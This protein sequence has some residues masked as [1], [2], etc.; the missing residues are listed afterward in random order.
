MREGKNKQ[1]FWIS[2]IPT[3]THLH[4]HI[5]FAIR[6]WAAC[7]GRDRNMSEEEYY[8]EG[9]EEEEEAGED[10]GEGEEEYDE[11]GEEDDNGEKVE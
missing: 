10:E 3:F 1:T 5:L 4:S 9:E 11:E 8:E 7:R 6:L 2:T